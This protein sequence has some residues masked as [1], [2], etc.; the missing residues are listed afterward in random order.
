MTHTIMLV[1]D[2]KD[3]QD[4]IRDSLLEY[5]YSVSTASN[6]AKALQQLQKDKV[7][8]VILDLGLPDIS[9]ETVLS[10]LEKTYPDIAVVILTGK[11]TTTDIVKGLNKGADDY[12]TKPFEMDELVARI[13]ARLREDKINNDK[14][15]IADL[16]LNRKTFEVRRKNRLI[17]LTPK[18]F[19]LLDY[20]MTNK[21]QVLSRE[22]ILNRVWDYPFDVESRTVDMYIGY[23]RRK[24]DKKPS[25]KLIHSVRG[26]GYMIKDGSS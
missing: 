11:S 7:D 20:L 16:T 26:F 2:D 12:I 8:L 23:L 6:G 15:T 13:K 9:G 4:I 1:E 18:E 17:H 10:E 25:S 21:N 3:L 5:G 14:L 19:K 22:R 24:I